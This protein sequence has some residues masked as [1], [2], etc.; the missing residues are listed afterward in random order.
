MK[1][2]KQLICLLLSG[3]MLLAAGCQSQSNSNASTEETTEPA[4]EIRS[5][6]GQEAEFGGMKL[7]VLSVE[8][9]EIIMPQSGKMA[10]F[11]QVQVD[12]DT[13]ET[14]IANYLNNFSLTVDGTE[15]QS[16]ECCTIPVMKQLYD[17]YEVDAINEEIPAGES[18]TGYVACEADKDFTELSLHYTPKT[19][20]RASKITVPINKE[21]IVKTEKK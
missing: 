5:E 14:V 15:Y 11:F 13:E 18:R 17:I 20:D 8:D 16:N 21:Q 1:F 6:L 3:L 2:S 9:P 19:T 12:N 4:T 10:I 7:T